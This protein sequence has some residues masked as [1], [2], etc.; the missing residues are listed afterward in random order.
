MIRIKVC[1][2]NDP[3]NVKQIANTKP[4]YIGFIFYP[5]SP[6]FVGAEPE[7][8][9]FHNVP[10]GIMKAGVF[11][12]ENPDKIVDLAHVAGIELVQLHGLESADYCSRLR[13]TGLIIVK[14][15]SISEDFDFDTIKSYS[16]GCDY[17]LFDTKFEKFGGSGKKFNWDVLTRYHLDK[18]F[19]LSGGIG[20]QDAGIIHAIKNGGFFA[21]DIN[22]RFETTPGIKNVSMVKTFIDEIKKIS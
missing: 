11:V 12:D 15:F 6:R 3:L 21:V 16:P 1:G 19:F 14:A 10:S 13:S 7:R 20:P 8:T 2:M 18:P 4:D 22:S 9:L 17:F 5:G